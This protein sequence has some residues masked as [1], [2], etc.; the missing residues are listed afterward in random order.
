MEQEEYEEK[1]MQANLQGAVG[2]NA[3][4]QA[5][6]Q[7][8]LQEQEKGLADAQL[9]VNSIKSEIYHLLRQDIQKEIQP[10]IF[11]WNP[12]ENQNERILSDWGVDRFMK[13]ISFYVNKNTLLSN[14]PEEEI[15]RLMKK[16][17]KELNDLIL[18]KYQV[19]FREPTFEECKL[20]IKNRIEEKKNIRMFSLEIMGKDVDENKVESEIIKEMEGTI[21][22]EIEKIKREQRKEKLRDYGLIINELEII[23]LATLRRAYRG[24]ERGSLRRH[25]T[26]SEL[27]GGKNPQNIKNSSG[28]GFFGWGN[29]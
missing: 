9:E 19:L 3:S 6:A 13:M 10:G 16:F 5:A 20:I 12:V 7:Y 14:F 22:F 23:V 11:E 29:K 26:V 2:Q 15:K 4:S 24:E 17:V 28:G 27:I 25:M 1:M 18:L 21:M 8:Y